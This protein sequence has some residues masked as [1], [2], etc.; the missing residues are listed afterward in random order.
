MVGRDRLVA[1]RIGVVSAVVALI[2]S[3]AG[4]LVPPARAGLV[5]GDSVP[6]TTFLQADRDFSPGD[7]GQ[8]GRPIVTVPVTL[9]A[10]QSRLLRDQLTVTGARYGTTG[11]CRF[12]AWNP[13]SASDSHFAGEL[14]TGDIPPHARGS[15][16]RRI[17]PC[18]GCRSHENP[19]A[20]RAR[21]MSSSAAS[22]AAEPGT[23]GHGERGTGGV[24][25]HMTR[26]P[27]G[28]RIC[29]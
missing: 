11:S 4:L 16:S 3:M 22:H 17:N 21:P 18:A 20:V 7:G 29:R 2:A 10:G 6:E 26:R 25:E 27:A 1:R 13:P 28:F 5:N 23:P 14:V 8:E 19:S 15:A 12:P 9:R 24:P